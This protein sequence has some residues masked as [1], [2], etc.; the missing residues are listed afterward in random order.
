MARFLA[1]SASLFTDPLLWDKTEYC[2]FRAAVDL[3]G[4]ASFSK[5]DFEEHGVELQLEVR[6]TRPLSV[7]F[8]MDRWGWKS[9]ATV[10]R[11]LSSL[12]TRSGTLTKHRTTRLG[13]T[14]LVGARLLALCGETPNET[15]NET[16]SGTV[17][18]TKDKK[19]EQKVKEGSPPSGEIRPRVRERNRSA[20]IA[21]NEIF[22][23]WQTVSGH[24]T[25][26]LTP[27]RLRV[28]E[29]RLKK[30]TADQIR[31]AISAA[32][33][34]P[35]YRGENET[36]TRYDWP[37]NILRNDSRVERF[38]ERATSPST[39]GRANGNGKPAVTG[40]T[41]TPDD[42][43]AAAILERMRG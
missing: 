17:N 5:R 32:C 39:N 43:V 13:N 37:E 24:E 14:Y 25:A 40:I 6:E 18:E 4:L 16:G 26:T 23:H 15:P 38:L 29:A 35:H 9:T 1:L 41:S 2:R 3:C 30:F 27:E 19:E 20:T 31:T 21:V 28:I 42:D 34:D 33:A 22:L 12:E 7:R 8:L 36:G 11:F 10:A